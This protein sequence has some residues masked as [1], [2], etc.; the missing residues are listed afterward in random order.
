MFKIFF[1]DHKEILKTVKV[2][3]KL[4]FAYLSI[5]IFLGLTESFGIALLF[6]ISELIQNQEIVNQY[7]KVFYEYSGYNISSEN[8]ISIIFISAFLLFL[9]SGVSQIISFNIA[10]KLTDGLYSVWQQ[11]IFKYYQK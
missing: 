7:T 10:A 8:L 1:R 11:K 6:P 3:Y 4:I 2:I 5:V 9:F